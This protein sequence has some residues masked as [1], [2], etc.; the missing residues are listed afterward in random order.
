M[1]I[2]SRMTTCLLWWGLYVFPLL[3]I[4]S[5]IT[6]EEIPQPKNGVVLLSGGKAP[7]EAVWSEFRKLIE[8]SELG[9]KLGVKVALIPTGEEDFNAEGEEILKRLWMSRGGTEIIILHAANR[10]AA[11]AKE[12]RDILRECSGVWI[13]GGKQEIISERYV[14]TPIET[15]LV[16]FL[17]R[18]GVLAGNSAGAAVTCRV[19]IKKSKEGL[20]NEPEVGVGFPF[21][22]KLVVDQHFSERKREERLLKMLAENPGCFG[23]GV[24]ERTAAVIFL[25]DGE[26]T[27][28]AVGESNA[29][30]FHPV[31]VGNRS[32]NFCLPK[33]TQP[34]RLFQFGN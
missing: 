18:G 16:G 17:N 1:K 6:A 19:M 28:Y 11:S 8:K 5:S 10:E 31:G 14:G 33:D 15:E 4:C 34:V 23:I 27:G 30:L 2:L 9:K 32:P 29:T 3:I 13:G 12:L 25:G 26:F 22:Q 21:L 7:P 20:P 24:D